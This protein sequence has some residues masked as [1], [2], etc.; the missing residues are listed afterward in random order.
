MVAKLT[1]NRLSETPRNHVRINC[2][3]VGTG[4]GV[5]EVSRSG[6]TGRHNK[7]LGNING[8]VFRMIQDLWVSYALHGFQPCRAGTPYKLA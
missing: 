3:G 1:L 6:I 7:D 8:S 4:K 2:P 5:G